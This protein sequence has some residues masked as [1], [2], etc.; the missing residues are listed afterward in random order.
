LTEEEYQRRRHEAARLTW[1]VR[2][3]LIALALI[4]ITVFAVAI[5][6]DPYRDGKVWLE[7]TH[8]Q[9]GLPPC[10]FR[11]L[12]QE[13]VKDGL[14]CPSCG[15]STSFALLVRG[16]VVNSLRANFAGTLLAVMVGLFVPWGLLCAVTGRLV[17]VRHWERLV[18]RLVLLFTLVMFVRWGIVLAVRIWGS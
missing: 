6:L 18:V 2:G 7:Q 4:P 5:A 10:T 17:G 14:P 16:D 8:T 3:G 15:M 1:W 11:V 13:Y 9:L 12:T